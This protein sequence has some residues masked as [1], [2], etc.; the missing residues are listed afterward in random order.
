MENEDLFMVEE[1]THV[2]NGHDQNDSWWQTNEIA[3]E[4]FEVDIITDELS[5]Y[6]TT[7]GEEDE[8]HAAMSLHKRE[9]IVD[10]GATAH[11]TGDVDLLHSITECTRGAPAACD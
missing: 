11:M 3:V 6:V 5:Q 7:T 1:D 10:S 8:C 9:A 4:E 2:A